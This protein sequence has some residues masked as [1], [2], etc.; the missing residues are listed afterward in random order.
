MVPPR[1]D[2][3]L[4]SQN[5]SGEP[6]CDGPA[7]AKEAQRESLSRESPP[8][9]ESAQKRGKDQIA[10]EMATRRARARGGDQTAREMAGQGR[11][12]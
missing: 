4:Q 6:S 11:K 5:A 1:R 3:K 8:R 9:T 7:T 12:R 10:R 2:H